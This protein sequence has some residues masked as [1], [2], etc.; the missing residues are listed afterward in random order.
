MA[1]Y[2]L[3]V[4]FPPVIYQLFHLHILIHLARVD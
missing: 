1:G 2:V 4:M 3:K